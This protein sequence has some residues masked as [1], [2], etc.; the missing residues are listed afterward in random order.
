MR[1]TLSIPESLSLTGNM[2]TMATYSII[3]IYPTLSICLNSAR[4]DRWQLFEILNHPGCSRDQIICYQ[5]NWVS[6][7]RRSTS[8]LGLGI[9]QMKTELDLIKTHIPVCIRMW[10]GQKAPSI[11]LTFSYPCHGTKQPSWHK[12]IPIFAPKTADVK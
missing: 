3:S 6:F 5:V 4:E 12:V 7:H 11:S 8:C 1:R 2:V 10:E 9:L